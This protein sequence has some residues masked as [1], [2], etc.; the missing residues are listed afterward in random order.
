[1]SGATPESTPVK[2]GSLWRPLVLRF[3]AWRGKARS[4][5]DLHD[6]TE[7][8]LRDIGLTV[9]QARRE[10]RR[11]FLVRLDGPISPPL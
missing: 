4:R 9:D 11:S 1:M 8:Q 10:S 3:L 7:D 6:L 2:A 5:Q